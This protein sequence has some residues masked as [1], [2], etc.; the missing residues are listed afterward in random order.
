ML[1]I[2]QKKYIMVSLTPK[3]IEQIKSLNAYSP[4]RFHGNKKKVGELPIELYKSII[5][6]KRI[7]QEKLHTQIG[8]TIYSWLRANIFY[9]KTV[10]NSP[11]SKVLIEG[12]TGIYLASAWY[13]HNDYNKCR[14][15][16]KNEQTLKLMKIF[17]SLINK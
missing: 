17:N 14:V 13:G 7:R 12:N 2:N 8:A 5:E 1:L 15:F 6:K 4:T 11:Y 9:Y 3:Q 10:K 16:Y